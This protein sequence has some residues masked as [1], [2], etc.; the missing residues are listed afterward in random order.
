MLIVRSMF[1]MWALEYH[2]IV[3][4]YYP[5][6]ECVGTHSHHPREHLQPADCNHGEGSHH[7]VGHEVDGVPQERRA[8]QEEWSAAALLRG[9]DDAHRPERD[10]P[11][12]AGELI[13]AL[14]ITILI[15]IP[16]SYSY[17]YH[18]HTH[19][20][21]YI[22]YSYSYHGTAYH[23]HRSE[24]VLRPLMRERAYLIATTT[25]TPTSHVHDVK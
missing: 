23:T 8:G 13:I 22:P 25:A 15:F 6:C 1:C 11:G 18:I 2:A 19:T 21:S 16:Y 10:E 17:S 14:I 24:D 12:A 20:N 4:L 5:G 9:V 3:V 7:R